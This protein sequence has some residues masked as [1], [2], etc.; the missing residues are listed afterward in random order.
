M[1]MSCDRTMARRDYDADFHT[2]KTSWASRFAGSS[3]GPRAHADGA[4]HGTCD[5]TVRASPVDR[6]SLAH[7]IESSAI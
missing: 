5:T 7:D 6:A 1:F 3:A 4:S 2:G